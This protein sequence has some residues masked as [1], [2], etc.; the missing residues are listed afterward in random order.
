MGFIHPTYSPFLDIKCIFLLSFIMVNIENTGLRGC[1]GFLQIGS[2]MVG[3]FRGV[4]IF[5]DLVRSACP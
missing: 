4:Q 1:S 5:V 3:N 2:H